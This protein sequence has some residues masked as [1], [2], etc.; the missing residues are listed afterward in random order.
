VKLIIK[1]KKT[2]IKTLTSLN[3]N[4]SRIFSQLSE[5]GQVYLEMDDKRDPF[6]G[7][8]NIT[9]KTGHGKYFDVKSLSGGE[10]TLVALSLI[11]QS[12]N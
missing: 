5:K 8:I 11:S 6:A 3:E 2:F 7:G 12:K 4:F 9:V 10:Q 1:K